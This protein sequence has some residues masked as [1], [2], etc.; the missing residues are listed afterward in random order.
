MYAIVFI[1]FAYFCGTNGQPELTGYD[2]SFNVTDLFTPDGSAYSPQYYV[3]YYSVRAPNINIGIVCNSPAG[4]CGFAISTNGFMVG[5]D[6]AIAYVD[7]TP[8]G[9]ILDFDLIAQNPARSA[10]C[11]AAV[12]PDSTQS[13]CVN[14]INFISAQRSSNFLTFEYS[15]PLVKSDSCDV[16]IVPDNQTFV[17]FAI[18]TV[19]GSPAYPF[20]LNKHTY[21]LFAEESTYSVIFNSK[22]PES[23][24]G[25]A[26]T[27]QPAFT[28]N[29]PP[30]TST[31][32]ATTASHPPTTGNNA[33]VTT[34]AAASSTGKPFSTT[35]SQSQSQSQSESQS[36]SSQPPGTT[37][38][39]TPSLTTQQ[40]AAG[41]TGNACA[42]TFTQQ[43]KQE[44]G[45]LAVLSCECLSDGSAVA[46]CQA[47]GA[48]DG[49]KLSPLTTI[50]FLCNL[51]AAWF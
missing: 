27:A 48:S 47:A 49:M 33:P 36:Q 24:T 21:R 17:I 7:T 1:F 11:S 9:H 42:K 44:C 15:R 5:S 40:A 29:A 31:P 3:V 19:V 46:Q 37:G 38:H 18:G 28:T 13:G 8:T 25:V 50:L 2:Y 51:I 35:G 41:T 20:N 4:W 12:C 6:A 26:T 32:A 34:A 14:N 22:I 30:T 45:T 43:C 23:T 39:I 10:T 16:A